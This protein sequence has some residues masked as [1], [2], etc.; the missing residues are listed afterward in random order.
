MRHSIH[1]H[2]RAL[3]FSAPLALAL[4]AGSAHAQTL[5]TQFTYQGQLNI[6][7]I[8]AAGGNVD[9]RFRVYDASTAGTQQG[10]TLIANN[11]TIQADGRFVTEL[12][13]GA[14]ASGSAARW[15]EIDVRRPAGSGNAFVTLTP[16]QRLNPTPNAAFAS[17]AG[18][19][20][21]ASN[22][23]ALNGQPGS[24]YR[25]ASNLNAGTVPDAQL[26]AAVARTGSNQNFTGVNNFNNASNIFTG[27]G[28][29]LTGI[30]AA[31]ITVGALPDARLSSNVAL[32]SGGNTFNGP[33]TFS[34]GFV[35]VGRSTTVGAEQ[36]GLGAS[37]AGYNGMYIRNENAAGTPFYGYSTPTWTMWTY[38]DGSTWKVYSN[39]DRLALTNTGNLGLGINNPAYKMHVAS[40]VDTQLAIQS[41]G[42]SG[43]T[44]SLQ[45]T[46]GVSGTPHLDAAFQLIDRTAGI[47]QM[48]IGS[49]GKVSFAN[50][51]APGSAK[52]NVLTDVN[53]LDGVRGWTTIAT[54]WGVEGRASANGTAGVRGNLDSASFTGAGIEGSASTTIAGSWAGRF[55]G[56]VT[57]QG[58]F[59]AT[60]KSFRIDHPQDPENKE[61][62]HASI[63]SDQYINVYSGNVTTD[64]TGYATITLPAWMEATNH[65][66]RYQLT[67]IDE[68]EQQTDFVMARVVSK[69]ADNKF[70]I[71]TSAPNVEVSWQLTGER[72]DAWALKNPLQ[73]EQNKLEQNRGKYINPE[74][75]GFGDEK[76]LEYTSR[77]DASA[78]E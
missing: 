8:P 40:D 45:S 16:R 30:N 73:V 34:G 19:A 66:F 38:L 56:N 9:L 12:D 2:I 63:E 52:L 18:T 67:V 60:S 4:L 47:A 6:F 13:F 27:N 43:R 7:G 36:F 75:F 44:W 39:G 74:A 20:A 14:A 23:D 42:P 65:N 29:G 55:F 3:A 69:V 53:S 31:N 33:Q 78:A 77:P 37:N 46:Q 71:K 50:G 24:F 51:A 25:N 17:S 61:L 32:R 57:V 76:R 54:G 26:P 72:K 5:G 59:S 15:I 28:A 68:G 48:T 70:A 58:A 49:N 22:A 10:A 1:S 21:N 64:A 11:V 41:T 62:W 35:G